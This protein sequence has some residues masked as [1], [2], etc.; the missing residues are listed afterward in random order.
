MAGG[1]SFPVT[2]TGM[3]SYLS[4][5][6]PLWWPS[7]NSAFTSSTTGGMY[8]T[9][10]GLFSP[11]G[12]LNYTNN[13]GQKS[14]YTWQCSGRASFW[15]DAYTVRKWTRNLRTKI[16]KCV[17]TK[18]RNEWRI[19]KPPSPSNEALPSVIVRLMCSLRRVETVPLFA[20]AARI[21]T[22][23]LRTTWF[24]CVIYAE[25]CVNVVAAIS[26]LLPPC[27]DTMLNSRAQSVPLEATL[28]GGG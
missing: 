23:N 1:G 9:G 17:P 25:L 15:G 28:Y 24:L 8:V 21:A 26:Q 2:C 16:R 19:S 22:K 3:L 11:A 5:L 6:I 14:W 18:Y 27:P 7:V 4:K 13:P 12:Y 20:C 10:G